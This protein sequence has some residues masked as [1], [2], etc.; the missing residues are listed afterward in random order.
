MT[1][2]EYI[3]NKY[4]KLTSYIKKLKPNRMIWFLSYYQKKQDDEKMKIVLFGIDSN[5]NL[6][7]VD[8]QK[9]IEKALYVLQNNLLDITVNIEFI[10]FGKNSIYENDIDYVLCLKKAC[11][12]NHKLSTHEYKLTEYVIDEL[13]LILKNK[14]EEINLDE[15]NYLYYL[16]PTTNILEKHEYGFS[17]VPNFSKKAK[18]KLELKVSNLNKD[19]EEVLSVVPINIPMFSDKYQ[20][21]IYPSILVRTTN[22][23]F[24]TEYILLEATTSDLSQEVIT[25]LNFSDKLPGIIYYSNTETVLDIRHILKNKIT[26][27]PVKPEQEHI[28]LAT[29][30]A[31]YILGDNYEYFEQNGYI[32]CQMAFDSLK[33]FT[34]SKN[35]IAQILDNSTFENDSLEEIEKVMIY[36]INTNQEIKYEYEKFTKAFKKDGV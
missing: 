9:Q 35:K 6:I 23:S 18:R 33:F 28:E 2:Y 14:L 36:L 7:I 1:N 30:L 19:E 15:N 16:N 10:Y 13:S 4:K 3:L 22:N 11:D 20:K 34:I 21:L 29:T 32:T 24:V 12:R 25:Y 27:Y 5:E 17:F 8:K 26:V 31:S